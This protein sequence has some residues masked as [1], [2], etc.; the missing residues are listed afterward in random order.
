MARRGNRRQ[1]QDDITNLRRGEYKPGE[2]YAAMPLVNRA[3]RRAAER[4]AKRA[5]RARR[6]GH[7]N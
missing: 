7:S 2:T 5:Q 1:M 4:D 3:D 6:K